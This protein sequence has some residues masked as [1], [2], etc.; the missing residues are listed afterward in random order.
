MKKVF[1]FLFFGY[2]SLFGENSFWQNL[3][4]TENKFFSK[5][6]ILEM[7][8]VDDN[9]TKRVDEN[10][11]TSI[12]EER[13][14]AYEGLVI[15]L[16]NEPYT[17]EKHNN[18]FY[19]PKK[20]Q[21]EINTLLLKIDSNRKMGYLQAVKRDKIR[22]QTLKLKGEI[23]KFL[24]Y[25]ADNWTNI[26]NK[27]LIEKIEQTSKFIDKNIPIKDI[28]AAYEE[29]AAKKG[30][31]SS[32]IKSNFFELAKHYYFFETFLDYLRINAT[33]LTYR[34]I[35]SELQLDDLITYIN[36]QP[37]F[38]KANIYLRYLKLDV[39]RLVL[40]LFIILF[41]WM[42]NY[43]VYK[44]L[45]NYFKSKILQEED[46]SDDILIDNLDRIRRPVS[47]LI[48]GIG[49]Q[50]ALEV[51]KY[52]QPLSEKTNLFFHIFFIAVI[53]YILM[54]LIE[55]IFF[56]YFQHQ[57]LKNNKEIRAELV[58]LMLSITKVVIFLGAILMALVKMGVNITGLLASLGIGG[59]AVALAA[60]TTLSNFFG[61]LKII[62]DESFS[63]GDWI[64]TNDVE[65]TVVEIGFIST[66][67]RTF[68]NALITVPNA[69]LANK[70]LKNWNK[71]T[72]GR[73]IKMHLGVTYGS[74]M[75]N[76]K[77]AIDEI[78]QMLKDHPGI[79]SPEKID[80]RSMRKRYKESGK[81][82]SM[83]DKLGIKSTMLV[84]LDRF[85]DSSIDIL[86]YTFTKTTNWQDWLEIKEDLLFKIWR[87]LQK[88]ELEFAFPSQTL[89]VDK[90]NISSTL[91]EIKNK[92]AL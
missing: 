88:H 50:L 68:D 17:L 81:F 31:I 85:S 41:F 2:V 11:T 61:L 90:E 91:E 21:K 80:K 83:E 73:R 7:I 76:L 47:L 32:Q 77:S 78:T 35:A 3:I 75:Q 51:V 34:S 40:F 8:S 92:K 55:N 46:E 67:I 14:H 43:L 82:L 54:Q 4:E 39:G 9:L 18:S 49:L 12:L 36:K 53:A 29:V 72:I 84:Y 23:Y 59:L 27:T 37:L 33:M 65:G 87:I 60:Q 62:F 79:I 38:S 44:R 63:Q 22:V 64:A 56:V 48:N 20:S 24:L 19:N 89:Y 30:A 71:R 42:L 57:K 13:I 16:K 45:Y 26:D 74:K 1:I 86:I 5:N 69:E 58:N 6:S 66:K 10:K 52:P 70:P 15:K 28:V 25:L